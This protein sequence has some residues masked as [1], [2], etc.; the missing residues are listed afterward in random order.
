MI[1]R[2]V[3]VGIKN[4]SDIWKVESRNPPDRAAAGGPDGCRL[5][6]TFHF[7]FSAFH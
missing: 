5:I 2:D 7:L 4:K 3:R 6:S 1:T